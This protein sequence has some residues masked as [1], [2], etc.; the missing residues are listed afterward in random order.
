M[1]SRFLPSRREFLIHLR[2]ALARGVP[3]AL[4]LGACGGAAQRQAVGRLP[5]A[6]EVTLVESFPVETELSHGLAE[7][8]GVWLDL[9]ER[10]RRTLDLCA[11][12]VSEAEPPHL[13][14]SRLAPILA[15]I[16]R[17]VGRGV[18]VRLLADARLAQTYPQALLRLAAAGVAVRRY[19]ARAHLGWALHAKYL[20]A[21]ESDAFIGSQ[22]LDWR[23]LAHISELG[24]RVRSGVLGSALAAL[25]ELDWQLAGGSGPVVN[26]NGHAA[27]SLPVR[28]QDGTVLS[29]AA[30]PRGALPAAVPWDLPRLVALLEGAARSI[31]V[32]V[33]IYSTASAEGPDG[34]R[35]TLLDDALRR[36][37]ARG[38]RVRLLVSEWAQ[39]PQSESLRAL[40]DLAALRNVTVRVLAVPAWSQGEIPF[41]RV[42][43]SKFLVVDGEPAA[44][45]GTKAWIGTSNWEGKYFYQSRNVGVFLDGSTLT[46]RLAAV[47]A[48]SF[49]SRYARVL[50]AR[51]EP[52]SP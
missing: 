48:A 19:D 21:D 26:G 44:A 10:A 38:V 4:V 24:L 18:R 9:V 34:S 45:G 52:A 13:A 1:R 35:F 16:E 40:Q 7:T 50:P 3:S 42:A 39:R 20:V 41:A 23:A 46:Q 17:A 49:S 27:A 43:H 33:L 11:Y 37:A 6:A 5:T 25:F 2:Q 29:L 12:Y 32:Q 22:N 36:A 8:A 15:A 47:F 28:A 31:D 51:T 14:T 30:S